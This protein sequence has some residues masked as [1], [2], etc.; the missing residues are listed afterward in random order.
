MTLPLNLVGL[1]ALN[2]SRAFCSNSVVYCCHLSDWKHVLR[3]GSKKINTCIDDDCWL[4]P[5]L[6][7][8]PISQCCCLASKLQALAVTGSRSSRCRTTRPG[9]ILRGIGTLTIYRVRLLGYVVTVSNV[10]RE[11][12]R[13]SCKSADITAVK[14]IRF[15]FFNF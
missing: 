6:L 2:L 1:S 12:T 15:V 7:L 3:K 8:Q 14:L 9:Q 10:G 11:D 13:G 4:W 5:N